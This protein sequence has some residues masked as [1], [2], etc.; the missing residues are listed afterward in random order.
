MLGSLEV[1]TVDHCT[2]NCRWCH[3]YSPFSPKREYE[4][5]EYFDGLD[6]IKDKPYGNYSSISLMGGEPFLHSDL[7]RFAYE[8]I[9][10]YRKPLLVTTNGFWMSDESIAAYKDLWRLLSLVK[11]SRYPTIEKR[12]GGEKE[13]RR[14]A[15]SIKQYNPRIRVEV[16]EKG[17][18]NKLE[19]FTEPVEVELFCGN[20][21]CI[22]LL[23]DM[24]MHRCG[25]GGYTHL[26]PEGMVTEEFKNCKDMSYDLKQYEHHSF[27]YWLARYPLDACRYC[28]FS[29]KSKG[30]KWKVEKGMKPFNDK[31]EQEYHLALGKRMLMLAQP[32]G[33]QREAAYMRARYGDQPEVS[34]MEGILEAR[35]GDLSGALTSFSH[36]LS[37]DSKNQEAADCVRTIRN[38]IR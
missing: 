13:L 21:R 31:Y 36:A 24:T 38:Q 23:P 11:I 14:L 6:F 15:N 19:F 22:A 5:R 1:H 9:E 33:A 10:R 8:M 25:A 17:V 7:T 26:A 35:S 32:E 20:S 30:G 3:N 18:F 2:N 37:L 12:L 28:S 4:A 34:I 29:L 16:A 27:V